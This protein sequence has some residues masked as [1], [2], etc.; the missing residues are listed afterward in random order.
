MAARLRF[1]TS[2]WDYAEWIGPFYRAAGE[3][4]LAAYTRVFN[5]VEINSTFYRAP[6]PGMVRGWIR[7]SPDDF[8]FAAKV[9][10]TVTHD[11]RLDIEKGADADT[12]AF[13]DLMAPMR[14][15]GKL[16]PL[17]LQLPPSLRFQPT[18]VDRFFG[19]FD[20]TFTWAI[21]FRN[22][23]W[24]RPEAYD[25]LK[26]HGIAYAIVDEPL[27]PPDVYVTAS[28]AYV[29]WHGRGADPWY[30]Y[31]YS[32]GELREWIPKV[33]RVAEQTS[34]VYGFFN[35]HYHG[36]APENCLQVLEMLG[37]ITDEQR[38]AKRHIEAFR[39]GTVRTG[40]AKTLT[41]DDFDAERAAR[42]EVERSLLRFVDA[43]RLERGRRIEA[44]EVDI[45][46]EGEE[47]RASISDY[48]VAV[49]PGSRT[50]IHNC[51]DWVKQTPGKR[52]CKHLARFFL[53]LP[54][55]EAQK[56]LGDVVAHRDAW[57]FRVPDS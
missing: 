53:S 46:R 47:I 4:K 24:L 39:Q 5:T 49:D 44:S 33:Q 52:M 31:R 57:A 27:L 2:G 43:A 8:V 1:G 29:R 28:S 3:S 10:Q 55:G 13:C 6:V 56:L 9:P 18:I 54:P 21:E 48:V 42:A 11:R 22:R 17:L 26:A 16:G 14:D 35:N 19:T 25:L 12:R 15:A 40:K 50:L 20:R 38:E 41:L 30:D 32:E 37:V 34:E 51:E 36:Y 7:H 23:T 45:A